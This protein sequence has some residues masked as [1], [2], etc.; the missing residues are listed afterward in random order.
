MFLNNI[1]TEF[2]SLHNKTT[3]G[4]LGRE[5]RLYSTNLW[6]PAQEQMMTALTHAAADLEPRSLS[7]IAWGRG[8]LKHQPQPF[9][10]TLTWQLWSK[11]SELAPQGVANI[12]WALAR[13]ACATLAVQVC[14][15]LLWSRCL[16]VMIFGSLWG[17]FRLGCARSWGLLASHLS[18]ISGFWITSHVLHLN[19]PVSP[20]F[21]TFTH[22][23]HTFWDGLVL[24][25][26]FWWSLVHLRTSP[27]QEIL[28][29]L[30][31][32]RCAD[33]GAQELANAAWGAAVLHI[34]GLMSDLAREAAAYA[35]TRTTGEDTSIFQIL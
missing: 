26:P 24:S 16:V 5:L 11:G 10:E 13:M 27:V 32:Q 31:H 8:T 7:N 28:S 30:I 25:A 4:C 17:Y 35:D 29:A 14:S 12:A 3:F 33:F 2:S 20:H 1:L 19:L 9:L 18:S 6:H 21:G 34:S 22:V 15:G 23:Y